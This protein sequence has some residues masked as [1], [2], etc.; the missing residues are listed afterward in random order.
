MPGNGTGRYSVVC[1]GAIKEAVR[2]LHRLAAQ[3][4]RAEAV[5][6]ALGEIS[7]RLIHDP[8]Q[9]GE[10]TFPLAAL[11]LKLRTIV[12]RPVAVDFAVHDERPFVFIR[13]VTLLGERDS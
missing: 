4:G 10:P 12:I 9:A 11:Q 7:Y 2:Q 1:S 8:L 3:Q 13:S 5:V 6:K